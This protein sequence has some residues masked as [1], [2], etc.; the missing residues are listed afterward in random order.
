[1]RIDGGGY[2]TGV[3]S[4]GGKN[5]C[6]VGYKRFYK[7][8][9]DG[10]W[11]QMLDFLKPSESTHGCVGDRNVPDRSNVVYAAAGQNSS[12]CGAVFKTTDGGGTWVKTADNLHFGSYE[13]KN[14]R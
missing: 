3:V 9:A 12:D 4:M 2:V 13:R 10:S 6:K 8:N 14:R 5:I 1:M 11:K 7:R